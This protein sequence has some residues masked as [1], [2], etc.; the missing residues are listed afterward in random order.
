MNMRAI[1][2][3]L[4]MALGAGG[5]STMLSDMYPW[6]SNIYP[7]E[8][9]RNLLPAA[10]ERVV[11]SERH[12]DKNVKY[13]VYDV[14]IPV[15]DGSGLISEV[16]YFESKNPGKK[17]FV[18]VLPI[19]GS[20]TPEYIPMELVKRLTYK[21]ES[22]DFNVAFIHERG[23]FFDWKGL[24][25]VDTESELRTQFAKSAQRILQAVR[26]VQAVLD[27]VESEPATDTSGIG[28]AGFSV[29]SVVA[30]VATGVDWRISAV[31]SVMGGGNIHDVFAYSE[32]EPIFS[33]VK[34]KTIRERVMGRFARTKERVREI[35]REAFLPAEL[36]VFAKHIHPERV[37]LVDAKFD[38]F[39]PW[40]SR[41]S[42]F[43]ALRRPGYD[44]LRITLHY[45]HKM[46]FLAMTRLRDNYLDKRIAAF[47]REKL[48]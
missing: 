13:R 45:D 15:H 29:G 42:L 32:A 33:D 21:N 36:T 8:Q 4:A 10:H 18:I 7:G 6:K 16:K 26:E 23:D 22:A 41:E 2:L 30:I 19:D 11:K 46:A 48:R 38:A 37:L 9:K 5:C 31:A 35:A 27:W 17:K 47:F 20:N 1:P 25:R 12:S 24:L 44:P 43:Q 39:L 14:S 3:L 34:I 40:S 28:I